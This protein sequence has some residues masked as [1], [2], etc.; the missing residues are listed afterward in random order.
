M[1]TSRR[2]LAMF[3]LLLSAV[4]A[5]TVVWLSAGSSQSAFTDVEE[6]GGNRLGSGR[7]DIEVGTSSVAMTGTHVAPGDRL[8]GRIELVNAGDLP[9]TYTMAARVDGVDLAPWVRWSLVEPVDISCEQS[10]QITDPTIIADAT[11]IELIGTDPGPRSVAAGSSDVLCLRAEVSL[12][13][14][15]SV[16][17][18]TVS[19]ELNIFAEHDW[20]PDGAG[21]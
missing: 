1:S 11:S 7:L 4:A 15:N 12:D 2:Q 21:Q 18:R 9:L 3:A 10:S 13:T 20:E 6:L 8:D 14:P 17:S 5:P 16:Q 19:I